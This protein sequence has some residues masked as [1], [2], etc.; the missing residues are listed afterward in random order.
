M[1]IKR[2]V[3][4]IALCLLSGSVIAGPAPG[5]KGTIN[6]IDAGSGWISINYE[7]LRLADTVK[8][9]EIDGGKL[10]LDDLAAEQHVRYTIN[11][12]G[13]V[14][15]VRVYDPHKLRQQGFYSGNDLNH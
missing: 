6:T 13:Q 4:W 1:N 10:S 5:V 2:L 7:D 12:L 3:T 15:S 9:S 11:R 8:V 14:D